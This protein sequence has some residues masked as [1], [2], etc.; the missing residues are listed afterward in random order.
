MMS[1]GWD[2][3]TLLAL[4]RHLNE[5]DRVECY[6]HGDV[7]SREL[8]IAKEITHALGINHHIEP[9]DDRIFA[10][11][12]IEPGFARTECLIFPHWLRAGALLAEMGMRVG[13]SGVYGGV[14]GGHYGPP[15]LM[16]GPDKIRM[17]LAHLL[18]RQYEGVKDRRDVEELLLVRDLRLPWYLNPDLMSPEEY[19]ERINQDIVES[20]DR[21]ES[22]GVRHPE[23]L[24]EAFLVESRGAQYMNGQNVSMRAFIDVANPFTG[25]EALRIAAALTMHAK[26]H[27]RLNRR[28]LLDHAADLVERPLAATLVAAKRPLLAQEV[29]RALRKTWETVR[30]RTPRAMGGGVRPRLGWVN[31]DFIKSSEM[32]K[33][34]FSTMGGELW[35]QGAVRSRVEGIHAMSTVG[36]AHPFFDQ[37]GKLLTVDRLVS[38]HGR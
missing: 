3:R 14:I 1:A 11:A 24:L 15:S 13:V 38:P 19:C 34:L 17:V 10:N 37:L 30:Q 18:G 12:T 2:S 5:T 16:L 4:F 29:S 26:I 20:L 6:S 27:N 25:G 31:F 33:R 28:M 22:R 36:N 9:I 8:R 23:Q 7:E 21:L 35:N 32:A